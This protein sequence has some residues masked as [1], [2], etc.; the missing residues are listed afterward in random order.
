M[1]Q[2]Q[3]KQLKAECDLEVALEMMGTNKDHFTKKHEAS[4]STKAVER[5]KKVRLTTSCI[6][7]HYQVSRKPIT[8][9]GEDWKNIGCRPIK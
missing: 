8:N 6:C 1:V 2:S 4:H 7:C 5:G 9:K 3:L